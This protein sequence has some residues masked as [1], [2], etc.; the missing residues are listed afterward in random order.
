M[1]LFI[2][3]LGEIG[4]DMV[5]EVMCNGVFDY[6]FKNNFIWFGLVFLYVVEI[7]ELLFVC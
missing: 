6:L 5:V 3:V 1:I 7:Y 2:L 4:E